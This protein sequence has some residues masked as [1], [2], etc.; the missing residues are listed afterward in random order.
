MMLRLLEGDE[1]VLLLNTNAD[2]CIIDEAFKLPHSKV[3][4]LEVSGSMI[5]VLLT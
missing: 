5:S 4:K 2:K 1:Q 3:L